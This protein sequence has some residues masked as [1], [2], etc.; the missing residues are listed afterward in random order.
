MENTS[1]TQSASYIIDGRRESFDY[2]GEV[3]IGETTV[4]LDSDDDL[5]AN[6]P[7]HAQGFTAENFLSEEE[8]ERLRSGLIDLLHREIHAL[9]G[10]PV[11]FTADTYHHVIHQETH[12]ALMK[13]SIPG[14]TEDFFPIAFSEI[15]KR[16]SEICQK[17]LETG[18]YSDFKTFHIR[19][20]RPRPYLDNN[21]PHRDVW[22][23]QLRNC[24]NI[25]FGV[26]GSDSDSALPILAGS[27]LWKESEIS[28][29]K[30]G[31]IIGGNT[32]KVPAV[33]AATR[34]LTM[35]RPNP[36]ANE[37]LVFSP[38]AI[39]GGGTNT[40]PDRTRISLEMRFWRR[41]NLRKKP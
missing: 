15:E 23:D 17:P 21:P 34:G 37:V 27:H 3:G 22:L 28:R 2:L 40:N 31:A 38:Y 39:H 41:G 8:C 11:N 5:T 12:Q 35:T 29:T 16:L 13:K 14:W 9:C 1:E 26:L 7:W 36:K 33:V 32:Y 4:L 25:Y 24:V 10:K 6:L 19:I 30:E 18:V 20:V